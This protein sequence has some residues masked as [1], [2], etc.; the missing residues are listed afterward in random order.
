[1]KSQDDKIGQISNDRREDTAL[2]ASFAISNLEACKTLFWGSSSLRNSSG[3][4][5]TAADVRFIPENVRHDSCDK[6]STM[7]KTQPLI[8]RMMSRVEKS[9][10]KLMIE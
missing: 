4:P 9:A 3:L 2:Q 7:C 8:S 1:M 5:G 10:E 6:R